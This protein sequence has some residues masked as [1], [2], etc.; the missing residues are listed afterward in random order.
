M[1]PKKKEIKRFL[2]FEKYGGNWIEDGISTELKVNTIKGFIERFTK[3]IKQKDAD[4]EKLT[5]LK[6]QQAD[7]IKR[8]KADY[9]DLDVQYRVSLNQDVAR[10]IYLEKENQKLKDEARC[11]FDGINIY[12][13]EKIKEFPKHFN[14][15]EMIFK[16]QHQ[17]QFN[18][19]QQRLKDMEK[20]IKNIDWA[21]VFNGLAY[22]Y[23]WTI[24]LGEVLKLI[25][26]AQ[27]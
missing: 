12:S 2:Y 23:G 3:S 20:K 4:V 17:K 13:V 11:P 19:L 6:N 14:D 10:I 18:K 26:E 1:K 8:L 22:D 9:K 5:S 7:L 27:K 25:K 16:V 21:K 24:S 15:K